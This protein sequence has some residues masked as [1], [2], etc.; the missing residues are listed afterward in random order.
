VLWCYGA[1]EAGGGATAGVTVDRLP[2][3]SAVD[4]KHRADICPGD[5]GTS[6]IKQHRSILIG[7]ILDHPILGGMAPIKPL[8]LPPEQPP[9]GP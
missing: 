5:A 4:T 9:D 6:T 8:L 7:S 2:Q 3:I 1:H